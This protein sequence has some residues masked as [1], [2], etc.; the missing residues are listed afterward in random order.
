[1]TSSSARKAPT[2]TPTG[3]GAVTRVDLNGGATNPHLAHVYDGAGTHTHDLL[4]VQH[5]A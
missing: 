1:T 4:S 2:P 5:P 3:P